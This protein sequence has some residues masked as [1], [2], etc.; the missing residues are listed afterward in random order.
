[1]E[2]AGLLNFQALVNSCISR[3]RERSNAR[4]IETCYYNVLPRIA[5]SRGSQREVLFAANVLLQLLEEREEKLI[6]LA[7]Q[8]NIIVSTILYWHSEKL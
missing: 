4:D 5:S 6:D 2:V 3:L 1:M 8:T 7:S